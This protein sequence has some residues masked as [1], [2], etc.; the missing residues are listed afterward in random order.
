MSLLVEKTQNYSSNQTP[1]KD[2]GKHRNLFWRPFHSCLPEVDQ[3]AKELFLLR[4]S[5]FD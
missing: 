4:K 1:N 5:N 3:Y 2:N